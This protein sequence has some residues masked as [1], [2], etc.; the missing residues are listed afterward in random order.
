MAIDPTHAAAID[1]NITGPA[2]VRNDQGEVH[3][4]DL[5]KQIA[6]AGKLASNTAA[7]RSNRQQVFGSMVNKLSP[8]G[9]V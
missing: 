8:P 4:H 2:S 3:Q 7:L 9:T 5:L 1:A 6:A